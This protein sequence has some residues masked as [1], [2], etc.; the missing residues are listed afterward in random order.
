MHGIARGHM[1]SLPK[2][3]LPAQADQLGDCVILLHGLDK[4][5]PV[6]GRVRAA[7]LCDPKS[8]RRAGAE[9]FLDAG[10]ALSADASGFDAV[11]L[12]GRHAH[13]DQAG[14]WEIELCVAITGIP[15]NAAL[16]EFARSQMSLEHDVSCGREGL[17]DAIFPQTSNALRWR[18][19]CLTR[20]FVNGHTRLPRTPHKRRELNDPL[21]TPPTKRFHADKVRGILQSLSDS[22]CHSRLRHTAF[23][24]NAPKCP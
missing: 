18:P 2:N 13:R 4:N 3:P 9:R 15:Q 6:Y 17:Q 21:T 8:D 7:N 5:L 23:D 11:S 14:L 24:R 16:R 12:R 19:T 1:L 10:H 20:H 22:L